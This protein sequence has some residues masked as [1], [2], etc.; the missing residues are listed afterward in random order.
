MADVKLI[1]GATGALGGE[2]CRLLAERGDKVRALVRATADPEKLVELKKLGAELAEGDLKDA[3]SL[4]RACRGAR[5]VISTAS[6]TLSRQSGDSIQ[7]VDLEGQMRLVDAAKAAGV[8]RFVFISFRDNPAIQFPLTKAKRAVERRLKESGLNY[9]VL[10]ASYFME[11]WL[12]PALGFDY[13]NA[14]ARIYG[15]GRNKLSWIS[16]ADVAQF[17]V[18]V[19]GKPTAHNAILE[20]GGPEALSPLEV[21][22]IFEEESGRK[23]AVE[24]VPEEALGAQKASASDPLSETFAGLMLQYAAGDAIEMRSTLATFPVKLTS[25]RQYAKRVLGPAA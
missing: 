11:V 21:V 16:F 3:A 23:F 13:A 19:L 4:E 6:S 24:H 20:I 14:K 25:V 9:T 8:G 5:A 10:Q 2:V 15:E 18:A 22:K 7:T 1:V 17:A 12:S